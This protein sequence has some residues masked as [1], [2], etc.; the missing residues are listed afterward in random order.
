MRTSRSFVAANPEARAAA[1][2]LAQFLVE[3][4][5][6]AEARAVFQRLW[7]SDRN[8]REFEFGVAVISVQMKDW[9][10]AESL[11]RDLKRANYGENGAVELYLAQIAEENGR[12]A[13]SDRALQGGARRRAR[14]GSRS[15]ASPR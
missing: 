14:R 5:R 10:T 2:G 3:Q 9:E 4:K 12:Y 13:G 15:C 11:F 7:D 1:G 6:Y 8:A